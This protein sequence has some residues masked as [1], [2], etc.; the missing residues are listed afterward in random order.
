MDSK[1]L[2]HVIRK[3]SNNDTFFEM[4]LALKG[5][6]HAYMVL[7]PESHSDLDNNVGIEIGTYLLG[8]QKYLR[9]LRKIVKRNSY[10]SPVSVCVSKPINFRDSKS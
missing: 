8:F 1:T 2:N 7:V 10:G 9:T 5:D 3:D 4:H 6:A